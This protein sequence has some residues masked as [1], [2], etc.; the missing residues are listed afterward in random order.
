MT[1]CIV[2]FVVVIIR[3]YTPR[4]SEISQTDSDVLKKSG[5]LFDLYCVYCFVLILTRVGFILQ[6]KKTWVQGNIL[7]L[8]VFV[9]TQA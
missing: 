4:F 3:F 6:Q 2:L 8:W 7:F 9:M 5:F 1:T